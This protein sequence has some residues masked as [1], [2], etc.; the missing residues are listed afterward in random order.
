[1]TAA[2]KAE[3]VEDT[4]ALL[5]VLHELH[6]GKSCVCDTL[7]ERPTPALLR[8]IHERF[9]KNSYQASRD[10]LLIGDVDSQT[11]TLFHPTGVQK[12]MRLG[13]WK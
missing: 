6:Q 3:K 11:V 13:K 7:A 5:E 2:G 4:K 9:S 12:T 1:M 8:T 10:I